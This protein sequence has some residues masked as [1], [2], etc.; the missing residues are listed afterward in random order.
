MEPFATLIAVAAPIDGV[1]V[2]TDRIIPARF[3][4]SPRSGGYGQFLFHD[5]RFA[6]D[7]REVADFVLNRA[8]YRGAR[9]LV[10]GRNFFL[11]GLV[12]FKR[13]FE[14]EQMLFAV[15][16]HQSLLDRQGRGSNTVIDQRGQLHRIALA[17]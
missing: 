15:I 16:A 12:N 4:K 3:I 14:D 11:I 9:I 5:L 8:P 10:A 6:D 7:G 2:D 1:N 17:I 13:Q